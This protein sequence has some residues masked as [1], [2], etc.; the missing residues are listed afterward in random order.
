[1]LVPSSICVVC[2]FYCTVKYSNIPYMLVINLDSHHRRHRF[3]EALFNP[4][5]C[6][7]LFYFIPAHQT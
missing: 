4:A 6:E 2:M 3:Y 5:C 1:M 7:L